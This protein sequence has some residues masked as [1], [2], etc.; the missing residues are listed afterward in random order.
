M[1]IIKVESI[2]IPMNFV[3]VPT[4]HEFGVLQNICMGEYPTF[5]INMNNGVVGRKGLFYELAGKIG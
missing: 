3:R 1:T 4:T 2:A 5:M